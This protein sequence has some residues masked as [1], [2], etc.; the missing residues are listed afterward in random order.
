MYT[1]EAILD[2]CFL[3]LSTLWKEVE[4]VEKE[5]GL[6]VF[7]TDIQSNFFLPTAEISA[8]LPT[9]EGLVDSTPHLIILRTLIS[10][11]LVQLHL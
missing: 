6:P 8:R 5:G 10:F 7:D 9:S 2:N 11:C 3:T 1:V 4:I